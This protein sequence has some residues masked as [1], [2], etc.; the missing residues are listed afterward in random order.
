M[1]GAAGGE[2]GRV[3]EREGR[4]ATRA[5]HSRHQSIVFSRSEKR[6]RQQSSGR[7]VGDK[8]AGDEERERERKRRVSK[9]EEREERVHVSRATDAVTSQEMKRDETRGIAGK[10]L[11]RN[12]RNERTTASSRD[13]TDARARDEEERMLARGAREAVER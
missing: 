8:E 1:S 10:S 3:E 9:S 12:N 11:T 6:D 2:T 4:K 13:K 7:R 5:F